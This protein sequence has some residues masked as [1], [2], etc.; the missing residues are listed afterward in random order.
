MIDQVFMDAVSKI[1]KDIDNLQLE[2]KRKK[3][4]INVLYESMGEQT[5]YEIE[6]EIKTEQSILSIRPDQFYGKNFSNAAAEYLRMKNHACSAADIM[7]GLQRGGFD[8]TWKEKDRLRNVAISL[9]KN[10]KSIHRLPNNT[11]GLFEWYPDIK[12][13]KIEGRKK[14][15]KDEDDSNNSSENNKN[16]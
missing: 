15:A 8:F 7:E 5:P 2:I 12:R 1:Q 6:G 14:V 13:K 4:A 11:F 9:S 10:S 16:A 3:Q